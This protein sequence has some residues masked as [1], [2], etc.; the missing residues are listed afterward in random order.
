MGYGSSGDQGG[1]K[2]GT[3]EP[4]CRTGLTTYGD[5]EGETTGLTTEPQGWGE[6]WL[7]PKAGGC[8]TA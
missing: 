3:Y 2:G 6:L 8:R 7:R 4:N 1:I 5:G